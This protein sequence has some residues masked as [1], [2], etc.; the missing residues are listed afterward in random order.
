MIYYCNVGT[1][2]CGVQNYSDWQNVEF[3]RTSL[4][5]P[6]SCCRLKDARTGKKITRELIRE[7]NQSGTLSNETAEAYK[8]CGHLC[9]PTHPKLNHSINSRGCL[10][11]LTEKLN[12]YLL[13]MGIY[14]VIVALLIAVVFT[15]S[16][17]LVVTKRVSE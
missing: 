8:Y 13:A 11:V 3:G 4:K 9:L 16:C 5:V 14:G 17:F 7:Q 1:Q 2:C 10:R 12:I 15:T 6:L